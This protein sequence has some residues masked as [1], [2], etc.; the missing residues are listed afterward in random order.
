M[1]SYRASRSRSWRNRRPSPS[2]S[3]TRARTASASADD[4]SR[5]DRPVVVDSSVSENLDP[6]MQAA[7][8]PSRASS[9]RRL[10]RR[11]M[12]SRRV[13]GRVG[14]ATSARPSLTWMAPS[15]TRA[16]T[17]S[18][19]NRGLPPARATSASGTSARRVARVPRVSRLAGSAHCRSSR[20][21]T[22]GPS[23]ASDSI[24]ST[25]AST[26][27]N[28]RP[29]SLVTVSGPRLSRWVASSPAIA[30][31]RGSRDE[32]VQAK[33]SAR[34]PKGRVRS[35]SWARPPTTWRPR[36][37]ASSYPS[38]SSRDL[39]TPASPSTITV[40]RWPEATRSN[41]SPSARSSTSRPR[42]RGVGASVAMCRPCYARAPPPQE[43][44]ATGG[45]DRLP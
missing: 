30:R 8:S 28:W 17:S 35:S 26:A 5:T 45:G 34:T 25:K 42:R 13:G 9:G 43:E 32:P 24:R 6:R 2:S 33:V 16:P 11:R 37:R 12:V 14:S 38:A 39:P 21:T 10:S 15:C 27:W 4:S 44:V 22:S 7:R 29:G 23:R 3:S 1:S 36:D 41:A 19:M 31:R 18:V 40:V 20:P